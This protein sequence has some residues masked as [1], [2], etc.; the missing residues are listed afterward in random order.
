MDRADELLFLPLEKKKKETIDD[1]RLMKA[2]QLAEQPQQ[3]E[4]T[5]RLKKKK[6]EQK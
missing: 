1:G 3:L 2:G 4:L 6:G 5:T